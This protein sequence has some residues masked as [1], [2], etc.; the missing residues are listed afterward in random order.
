MGPLGMARRQTLRLGV[1]DLPTRIIIQDPRN[2]RGMNPMPASFCF[3]SGKQG[4]PEQGKVAD[5]VD[6]LVPYEFVCESEP[7][8]VH[9]A[10]L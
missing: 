10:A 5:D 3:D 1:D 6:D 8:F 7:V 9:E 4:K 2:Q